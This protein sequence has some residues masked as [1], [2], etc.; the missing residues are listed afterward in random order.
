M[1]FLDYYAVLGVKKDA[2]EEEIKKA[3]RR[4]ARK[5]HPDLNPEDAEATKTFARINEA[6]EVLSDPLKR[7]KY[8]Q[9][10]KDWKHS[11]AFEKARQQQSSGDPFAR[12][13]STGDSGYGTGFG[14]GGFGEGGGFSDFFESLFGYGREGSRRSRPA[15]FKGPDI[16][17]TLQ[18][19]L[20][21][22][23]RTHRQT[24]QVG[25][26][27]LRITIPAGVENGQKIRL[28]G[29]GGPGVE[30]GPDGDLYISFQI[31]PHPRFQRKGRDI[32]LVEP[33]PLYTAILGGEHTVDLLSGSVKINIA[34]LTQNGSQVRLKGK[35]FPVYKEDGKYGDLYIKWSVK[36]PERLTAAQKALFEKLAAS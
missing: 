31:E 33:L 1:E 16:Q 11:E 26:K 34:P 27:K 4:L 10:G 2:S 17:A 30:G 25:D 14:A 21:Q 13:Y 12:Q 36:L 28:K 3:F 24:V 22:A 6:Y 15:V 20:E 9:Y 8:D 23:Y 7:K 19:S 32:Y 29:Q 35:G 18:L 5:H